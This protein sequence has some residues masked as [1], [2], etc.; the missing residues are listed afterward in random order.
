MAYN[1]N[2]RF[3][4]AP[5][6]FR[7]LDPGAYQST[8]TPI[9]RINKAPFLSN[10]ERKIKSGDKIWT[11]TIY[12]TDI[13]RH[14]SN[15]TA[16]MSK[17]PRFPYEAN[18]FPNIDEIL[19]Q[20]K[21][22]N[23]CECDIGETVLE[24]AVCKGKLKR[25]IF[26]GHPPRS[27]RGD[28]LSAPSKGG[29]RFNVLPD[30]SNKRVLLRPEKECPPFYNTNITE[31][32]AFYRGCKWS[33]RTA[34]LPQIVND[35]PGPDT[36]TLEHD[37]TAANI[38]AEKLRSFKRRTS[39]QYRFID[40][41]QR[42]N[43]L[44][45]LPGP[46]SY[47]PK[48]MKGTDLNYLGPKAPRFSKTKMDIKWP[49]PAD[50]WIRRDFDSPELPTKFCHALL[51][52]R[53]PFGSK[54]VRLKHRKDEGPSPAS[55]DPRYK[56]CQFI[57]CFKVPFFVSTQ[58]FKDV[59]YEEEEDEDYF[60]PANE[61]E[62]K[63]SDEKVKVIP[64][65]QFKSE[66][67]R[68]KPLKKESLK[69]SMV[70]N[71]LTRKKERILELQQSA[72]FFSSE[73][74]FRPWY[75]WIP[76]HAREK[77]PGPAYYLA[78]Q[79]RCYPAVKQGPLFRVPRF[80]SL[81]TQSPAPNEYH[82]S[83]GIEGILKTHNDRLKNNIEKQHKFYW[84][85]P[86]MA[87]KLNNEEKEEMLLNQSIALLETPILNNSNRTIRSTQNQ[88]QKNIVNVVPSHNI[89]TSVANSIIGLK[90]YI[91]DKSDDEIVSANFQTSVSN[92]SF[93]PTTFSSQRNANEDA[94]N[95]HYAE[96]Q[97][98]GRAIAQSIANG[99]V[100]FPATQAQVIH[101]V[102]GV[103]LSATRTMQS[104]LVIK[105]GTTTGQ[106]NIQPGMMAV[107]MTV[108]SSMSNTI[109]NVMTINKAGGQNG[110]V[111]AQN[112]GTGQPAIIPNVQIL[113]TRPAAP[114]VAAQKSVATV[115]PRVVIGTPQVVGTR[116]AVPGITL[117]TLQSLQQGQQGHLLLKTENGQYQ[118]LR[119]GPA[120]A[121]STL[122][123]PQPQTLRLS[124]VPAHPGVVTVSTSV[125]VPSQMGAM[126]TG[127]VATPVA[128]SSVTT[129]QSSAPAP[130][131]QPPVVPTQKPLDNTKEKC[132][133]FLANLLDLSSKE[134][135]SVER[136][137]RNLIQELIDA[138][139][140][141]EEFCDRLERL[142]NASPQPCLIG[143][144]KKSLPLLRQSMCTKELV[145]EGI[146][147]PSPHVAFSSIPSLPPPAQPQPVV[148]TTNL[149]LQKT[150]AKPGSSI[151]VLQNIPL[152][153]KT[154]VSKVGKTMTVNSKANFSRPGN[155]SAALSTVL[156]PGR[157]LLKEREKKSTLQFTQPF[158]DDK[159]TGDDDI[160]DVA[161]MGGVNLA[162]ETQ[163]IL[164]STELIGTQI[165]SI[166]DEFLVPMGV[167]Q[168]RI[169]AITNK[170]G[171]EDA[172]MDVASL[173]CHAVHERLKT[174]VE[175]L[176]VIAQQRGDLLIKGD[177]RFEAM[178]DFKGQLK[179]LEELDRV[180]RKRR[181]DSEREILLRAAKS[182]SKNEDPEQA[183]LKAKAK[184]MQRAELEEMRQREA[185][186]TALQAIGPRKKARLEG[187]AETV[188]N[189]PGNT[190]AGRSQLALRTRL[191]R[192][193][194][195]DMI[196]LLEQE[197]EAVN[198]NMLFRCYL[199]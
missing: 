27:S 160:N 108:N 8:S 22:P 117:Q 187:P 111:T 113:N 90:I 59:V 20:C 37:P 136:N 147:P 53:A 21:D 155:P 150:P 81:Q 104:P 119:V 188:S 144:L 57:R 25:T 181:E 30:G 197:N 166:K 145:I 52:K 165:R 65:W 31:A 116:A 176:A 159:M 190:F 40:M 2:E 67:V 34:K 137:V 124:T 54:S 79:A 98:D 189:T 127:P 91:K 157:S 44:D 4:P 163:R 17:I 89:N 63:K 183:K 148:A 106:V 170:H 182:R 95:A 7:F 180:D 3:A 39:K 94:G 130:V 1:L 161:A 11:H 109:P 154:N 152:S 6:Y 50:H 133:N 156:T 192:I 9:T 120:P 115:S 99:V 191:K 105:Q 29:Q 13:K 102:R 97:I 70:V 12:S 75:N 185:N 48:F 110:V 35:M 194:L 82:V 151:A 14:I 78:Q 80:C 126:P 132:R 18:K 55:Y 121:A 178:Q 43:I 129:V 173:I 45:N 167:M 138:Q 134:P 41:V 86:G 196:C 153:T 60:E 76:V 87:V 186:L 135:K 46:C 26:K 5:P 88:S 92:A 24:E 118:L 61:P 47:S 149:Q 168:S 131:A 101:S 42:R 33:H 96:S 146:N 125:A 169:K 64:T 140:E 198:T 32:N 56:P 199:K 28:G 122:T 141:P 172:S 49:G 193:N 71:E 62:T 177:A 128:V 158:G 58:R 93:N 74:R 16:L 164:G 77:T 83:N 142:L 72:P 175:K 139:V 171:L 184:E 112:I 73:A 162:E 100:A 195:R 69:S 84:E 123:A 66:T 114:T 68:M 143:F 103:P 107:P 179:F 10:C 51:P 38:C 85:P 36:Y 19:C 23:I 174:M 15:C